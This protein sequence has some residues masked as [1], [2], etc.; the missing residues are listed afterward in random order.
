ML[1]ELEN[2]LRENGIEFRFDLPTRIL[3]STD[4]SI[5]RIEPLGVAFP[6]SLDELAAAVELA[7]SFDTPI[8]ARGSGSSLAGQAIGRALILDCS[9]YLTRIVETNPDERSAVVEPG[10]ILSSLNKSAAKLGL[11]FGPD[12]ASAER[13]T[14][15]GS[16]A[17]NATGAHSILYGMAADHL[18]SADVV[19][20]DGSLATFAEITLEQARK[21]AGEGRAGDRE[22]GIG[23][24]GGFTPLPPPPSPLLSSIYRA[25]LH[26]REQFARPIQASWPHTWRKAAGYNLNYLLPWSPGLPPEWEA[27]FEGDGKPALP[28]PPVSHGSINLS[29]LLAGSEGTLAVLRRAKVRLVPLPRHT[30]LGVLAFPGIAQACQAVPGILELGPSA[31]ELIPGILVDL[32]RSVPAFGSQLSIFEGLSP[33]N[34][35]PDWLVVE[36]SGDE[37]ARLRERVDRL[38]KMAS[39]SN[40]VVVAESGEAQ[41]Q[42]WAVRKV[43]LGLL[44]SRPGDVRSTAFI[45]DLSVPV[46]HLG[47]FVRELEHI[48]REHDTVADFYAH[49]SAGC[50]HIRPMVNLKSVEGVR[51]LRS[52]AGQAVQLTTRFHGALSGEHGLGLARSEWLGQMYP[53]EILSAFRLLKDAADPKGLLNP[54]K[55]L[56]APKMDENLR[57]GASIPSHAWQPRFDFSSQGGLS[58][59]IEMCNGAGVC[60]KLDGVMC[61]S[62]QATREE[63]HSTRGRA[64]LLREMISLPRES[65]GLSEISTAVYEALDLC[66]ACKGCKA[67]CPSSVDMAK[68][69]YEFLHHYY[70]FHRRKIRDYLFAFIG[71]FAWLGQHFSAVVNPLL[72]WKTTKN[73]ADKWLGLSAERQFP[74]LQP[75]SFH[76]L[77]EA[78]GVG[79]GEPG[80]REDVLLLSDLFIE[81]FQHEVGLAAVRVLSALGYQVRLIPVIGSGRTMISKG[82]LPEARRHAT[83]L[84][85]AIQRLDPSGQLPV[86]GLE[87]SE[88]YTLRDEYYDLL[89]G[90]ARLPGL[91]ERCWMIDEFL[92]RSDDDGGPRLKR[93]SLNKMNDRQKVLLHGHC[94][95]K[96]QPLRADG[97]PVGAL[98]SRKM[99]ALCGYEV[100]EI[101]GTC[102]GMAGAFG[103]EKEHYQLSM[104][105]GEL[106]LFP[107]L[108]AACHETDEEVI[109]VAAGV[110]CQ[111]QIKDGVGRVAMHPIQLVAQLIDGA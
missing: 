29:Q 88:I 89:H 64:N 56:D 81:Y 73:L 27:Q 99:L 93:L 87:P 54:G 6:K 84:V 79:K 38:R 1:T 42:V 7:A 69:R 105:V 58:G 12:P 82:F 25:A 44:S 63:M 107:G 101:E 78:M 53:D 37:P 86:I 10:V 26:I 57:Y 61:P 100:T 94:Y 50:L 103:Y 30:I 109:I 77:A 85:D 90:D 31:V 59:A 110:S 71:S 47:G 91:A 11:Q 60:R 18:I 19:L 41:K 33:A 75:R 15:G 36:F 16:L 13:A 95:Q 92:L 106:S 62:F 17:N 97:R 104:D 48:F 8:L 52:I 49:A 111:A 80:K 3:Y 39:T 66:L 45:E 34:Q 51:A 43:G 102:C 74:V 22:Q 70:Q 40:P 108:R 96:A 67:E 35:S 20:V 23:D 72:G 55:I 24:R 9:R 2:A 46:E 68:L 76:R 14:M 5:Y 83:R 98:A 28:Y 21:I 65:S 4:A 32:A